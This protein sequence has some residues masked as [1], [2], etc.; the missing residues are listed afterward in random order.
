[1]ITQQSLAECRIVCLQFVLRVFVVFKQKT[2][3][4]MLI[5]D[6]S[7]DVCSSDLVEEV[8][9]ENR[10]GN[11]ALGAFQRN[12][13]A[14]WRTQD[15]RLVPGRIGRRMHVPVT[16]EERCGFRQC[17]LHRSLP[18]AALPLSCSASISA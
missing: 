7:S 8:V 17:V 9:A 13:G 1:M 10:A 15:G 6:W 5:S 16:G 11:L 18:S 12:Q 2:A 4:D 14:L 3:Y